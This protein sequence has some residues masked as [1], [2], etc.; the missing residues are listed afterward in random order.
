MGKVPDYEIYYYFIELS[1]NLLATS[2]VLSYIIPNTFLFNTFAAKYR[3]SLLETWDFIEIL[4]CTK[5]SVFSSA[6]VR[7]TITLWA[8]KKGN[9]VGYRNTQKP[10]SFVQLISNEREYINKQEIK[11]LNQNWAL[12]FQLNPNVIKL[13]TKIKNNGLDLISY[14]PDLSQG[15]IAYD[16]YTGQDK[17]IIDSRAYH[18]DSYAKEGLKK[19]MLGRN[20]TRYLAN[21]NGE[22]YIDYCDGIA[23]PRNPKFF[24]GNRILVREITNP[25]IYAA[26]TDQELYNDPSLL[27]IKD[28]DQE[29][30]IFVSAILNSKLATFFHFNFSPKA[31]KGDFPKILVKDLKEFP[32]PNGFNK[33]ETIRL[34]I[35]NIV[36]LKT[37]NQNSIYYE[38]IIDTWV[39]RLYDLSYDEVLIID[40]D[41]S[42]RMSKGEYDSF[43][44]LKKHIK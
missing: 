11:M 43:S 5:F 14:F 17:K 4:D 9:N 31:T 28:N 25:S 34:I 6:T 26:Y 24:V 20:V 27:I 3:L 15:L 10:E 18:Y 39:Y 42:S 30:L 13:V 29:D 22:K 8:H 40:P 2:G 37:N 1:K 38:E 12:A 23:N 44:I 33:K 36:T 35:Q 41:Y 16:K 32:I 21:W 19:W 7:N